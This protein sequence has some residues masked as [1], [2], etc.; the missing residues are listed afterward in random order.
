MLLEY[1]DGALVCVRRIIVDTAAAFK[2]KRLLDTDLHVR[3]VLQCFIVEHE[4]A[5]PQGRNGLDALEFLRLLAHVRHDGQLVAAAVALLG[6]LVQDDVLHEV[7]FHEKEDGCPVTR[8]FMQVIE[9][10]YHAGHGV[11]PDI[12]VEKVEFGACLSPKA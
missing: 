3:S 1:P 5:F 9:P 8:A 6:E 7:R 4:T 2:G 10:P 12:A 11:L